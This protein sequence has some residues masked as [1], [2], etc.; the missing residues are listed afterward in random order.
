M[1]V[2]FETLR[3]YVR[4]KIAGQRVGRRID[5]DGEGVILEITPPPSYSCRV[6]VQN[7]QPDDQADADEQ[8]AQEK[9]NAPSPRQELILRKSGK[10]REDPG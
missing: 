6:T 7:A 4:D 10:Q 2:L 3:R 8:N 5:A 9:R 1:A